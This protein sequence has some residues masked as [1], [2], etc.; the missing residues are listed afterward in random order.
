MSMN[1]ST[2]FGDH[3][4]LESLTQH[5]DRLV[6]LAK[7]IRWEPLVAVAE[8]IWRAGAEKKAPCGPKPWDAEVMVRVLVLKRLS[9]AQADGAHMERM[10]NNFGYCPNSRL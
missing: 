4:A 6:E 1:Q 2:F 7:H 8:T 10:I 3:A 9:Q 5:G